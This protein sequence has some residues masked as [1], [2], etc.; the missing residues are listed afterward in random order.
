MEI[1]L[2][3]AILAGS[4]AALGEVMRLGDRNAEMVRDESQAQILASSVMDELLAGSMQMMAV[5]HVPFD[6]ITEPQWVYSIAFEQTPYVEL[7]MVRVRVEQDLPPEREPAVFEIVRWMPNPDY[8]PTATSE[9]SSGSS[10]SST[11]SSSNG[12]GSTG[13][14][15]Q[16]TG[17]QQ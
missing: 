16:G 17:G 2:S 6:Y 4:L 1:V 10:G 15:G 8:L 5:N 13:T 3:L 11:S 12:S 9:Q 14:G 7:L